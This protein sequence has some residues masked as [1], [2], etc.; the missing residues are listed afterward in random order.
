ML[1]GLSF[2]GNNAAYCNI[3]NY[4]VAG[5][6]LPNFVASVGRGT[7]LVSTGNEARVRRG[8]SARRKGEAAGHHI[9]DC[10]TRAAGDE[11]VADPVLALYQLQVGIF[12]WFLT[13]KDSPQTGSEYV[14]HRHYCDSVVRG[15]ASDHHFFSFLIYIR[16]IKAMKNQLESHRANMC[17]LHAS[18]TPVIDSTIQQVRESLTV[19]YSSHLQPPSYPGRSVVSRV[20]P[21]PPRFMPLI[22]TAL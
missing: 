9:A 17:T 14:C 13:L 4:Y 16:W 19:R 6:T 10:C 22:F 21:A 20:H 7:S 5:K 8:M 18:I 3:S 1:F 12:W 11:Y 15:R 2:V